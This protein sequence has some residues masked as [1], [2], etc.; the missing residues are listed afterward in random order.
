M[1]LGKRSLEAAVDGSIRYIIRSI[2]DFF[3][4]DYGLEGFDFNGIR[5]FCSTY[6]CSPFKSVIPNR[7][8]Y[9][10]LS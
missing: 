1:I 6:L 2:G 9:R 7:F 4:K 8:D 3:I 5:W 10:I